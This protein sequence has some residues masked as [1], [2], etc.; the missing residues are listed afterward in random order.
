MTPL[1]VTPD[2]VKTMLAKDAAPL[3]LDVRNA[4]EHEVCRIDGSVLIP[5]NQLASRLG[6]ISREK[7]IVVYCHHGQRSL[8]AAQFLQQEGYEAS[9]MR[10]GIDEWAARIEPAMVRY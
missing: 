6:E 7:P 2:D 3:L 8:L 5:L 1:E 4:W 10:G 9:S